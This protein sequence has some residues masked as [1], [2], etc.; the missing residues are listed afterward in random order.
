MTEPIIEATNVSKVLGSGP[1]KVQALKGVSIT[2]KG[3]KLTVLIGPSG[4]GKTTLLSILGCMLAPTE[5]TVRICGTAIN[6]ARPEELAQIRRQH[7]GFASRRPHGPARTRRT[8][9]IPTEVRGVGTGQ[10]RVLP[11]VL[12]L[13]TGFIADA[14]LPADVSLHASPNSPPDGGVVIMWNGR[15]R[16]LIL[17]KFGELAGNKRI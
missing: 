4:S 13:S 10:L 8:R 3:G 7:I 15:P 16:V 17:I 1:A 14:D 5:G 2:L 12:L 11:A 6:G 9:A